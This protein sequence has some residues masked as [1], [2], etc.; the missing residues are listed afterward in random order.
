[1]SDGLDEHLAHY[2]IKGMKW[3]KRKAS[4]SGDTSP[5][6]RREKK[7]L[8]PSQKKKRRELIQF[9]VGVAGV[10]ANVAIRKGAQWAVNNPDKVANFMT[11][12]NNLRNGTKAIGPGYEVFKMTLGA[13]G[14][15]R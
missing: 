8:T 15:Y 11:R 9:S 7:E 1:M 13:S 3:G 5:A 4:S 12:A 10:A 6:P 14:V 2:G